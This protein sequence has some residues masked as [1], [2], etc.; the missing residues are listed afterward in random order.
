MRLPSGLANAAIRLM[1][2]S[3]GASARGA[4]GLETLNNAGKPTVAT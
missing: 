1:G 3:A 4:S 2:I